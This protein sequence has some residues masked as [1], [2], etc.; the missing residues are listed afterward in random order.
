MS[1]IYPTV[2]ISAQTSHQTNC[3]LSIYNIYTDN[4]DSVLFANIALCL[5]NTLTS[6]TAIIGNGLV[7]L[8][9]FTTTTLH[10]PSNILLCCLA[11]SDFLTGLITQP[12]FVTSIVARVV[13]SYDVYCTASVVSFLPVY[14]LSGVSFL[15]LTSVSLDRFMA[16]RFHLRYRSLVTIPRVLAVECATFIFSVGA[17]MLP[18]VGCFKSFQVLIAFTISTSLI[19]NSMAYIYISR[20]LCKHEAKIAIQQQ[21]S[22]RFHCETVVNI[23]KLKRSSRTMLSVSCLFFVCYIPTLFVM[24]SGSATS[25][26]KPLTPQVRT[27]RDVCASVVL[28]NASLNPLVY[29]YRMREI[30]RA[31]CGFIS[32]HNAPATQL[33]V[34]VAV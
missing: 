15:T 26:L 8:S 31:V 23:K 24:I 11:A 5:V 3:S 2:N 16:L 7:M 21:L 33:Q 6:I 29:C 22:V 18:I 10:S 14:I 25:A 20:T 4:V 1:A 17:T 32:R 13:K 9:I 34:T 19:L 27:V 28:V 12:S 30:R